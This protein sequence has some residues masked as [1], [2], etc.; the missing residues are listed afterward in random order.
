MVRNI[1]HWVKVYPA[2]TVWEK[3]VQ[4]NVVWMVLAK[5]VYL[6]DDFFLPSL[7]SCK[8]GVPGQANFSLNLQIVNSQILWLFPVLQIHKLLRR[9]SPQIEIRKSANFHD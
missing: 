3:L 1:W 4:L 5:Y 7:I 6:E 2:F 9:A 8:A